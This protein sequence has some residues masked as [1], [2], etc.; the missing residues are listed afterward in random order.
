MTLTLRIGMIVT[1]LGLHLLGLSTRAATVV[2]QPFSAYC[3]LF[4]PSA[5]SYQ[6]E[7]YD[8]ATNSVDT[9]KSMLQIV[10]VDVFP[11]T[12]CVYTFEKNVKSIA[13]T[14]PSALQVR[15][16]ENSQNHSKSVL[17]ATTHSIRL[18]TLYCC[19]CSYIT[20]E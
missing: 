6:G 10:Y 8:C 4:R 16:T 5:L 11:R 2:A 17:C 3:S 7:A 9:M 15:D 14:S 18:G 12:I 19:L 1:E 13:V 20:Y